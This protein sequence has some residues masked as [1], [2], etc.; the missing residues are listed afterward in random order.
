MIVRAQCHV[1][2]QTLK[3]KRKT[4]TEKT[5]STFN[6]G[7]SLE[8]ITSKW[9]LLT[10]TAQCVKRLNLIRITFSSAHFHSHN[11]AFIFRQHGIMAT[12]LTDDVRLGALTAEQWAAVTKR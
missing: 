3:L 12:R 11:N 2:L 9:L 8:N 10:S 4:V 6:K 5:Y 1:G 7:C